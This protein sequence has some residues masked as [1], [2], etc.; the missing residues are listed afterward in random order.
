M[1][2]AELQA[3]LE[4]F[5]DLKQCPNLEEIILYSDCKMAV[6]SFGKG[7]VY[8]KRTAC[9]AIWE[10]FW[11]LME[12]LERKGVTTYIRKVKAHTDDD[13]LAPLPLRLGNQ[14]ADHYMQAL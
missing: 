8:T 1:P 4:C 13:Q 5:S 3:I 12:K 9:G 10:D 11:E 7:K 6:D 14:C 2:W